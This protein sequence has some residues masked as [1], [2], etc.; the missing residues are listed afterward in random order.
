MAGSAKSE[1]QFF[2]TLVQYL[3]LAMKKEQALSD[4]GFA[5]IFENVAAAIDQVAPD[6]E[7]QAEHKKV[8]EKMLH[9]LAGQFGAT[10]RR[11]PP[12]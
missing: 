7:V 12:N 9:A 4:D 11:R 2:G 8:L 10:I 5:Y 3:F 6:N 1:V